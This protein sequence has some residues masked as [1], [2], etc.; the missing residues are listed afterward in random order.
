MDWKG[1]KKSFSPNKTLVS[2]FHLEHCTHVSMQVLFLTFATKCIIRE[3]AFLFWRPL[4]IVRVDYWRALTHFITSLQHSFR[5]LWH[6]IRH[7]LWLPKLL[8]RLCA[9]YRSNS[10]FRSYWDIIHIFHHWK[11]QAGKGFDFYIERSQPACQPQAHAIGRT[12]KGNVWQ[13]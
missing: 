10:A 7:Q 9:S 12:S 11:C 8:W 13:K 4:F 5:Y 1:C 2:P 6:Q 3:L